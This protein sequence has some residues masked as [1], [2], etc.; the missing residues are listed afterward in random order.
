MNM[1]VMTT[2]RLNR[3]ISRATSLL[4]AVVTQEVDLRKKKDP[5]QK[6]ESP[7]I[8]QAREAESQN[9]KNVD[10]GLKTENP[11]I[12]LVPKTENPEIDQV[13]ETRGLKTSLDLGKGG[14]SQ[15][16]VKEKE[17]KEETD[18][19]LDHETNIRRN[20]KKIGLGPEKDA[21]LAPNLEITNIEVK[22]MISVRS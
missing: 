11:E 8:D 18:Q 1:K 21:S 4:L 16:R 2:I 5:D 12:D 13:P 17:K 10:L 6:T 7:E 19:G 14:I 20:I 9:L 22:R 3:T 15:G